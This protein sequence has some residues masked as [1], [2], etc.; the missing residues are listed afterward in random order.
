MCN[1]HHDGN[2]TLAKV[3]YPKARIYYER[4][5]P[6]ASVWGTLDTDIDGRI[7]NPV[8]NPADL[9]GFHESRS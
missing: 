4:I 2:M 1:G 8:T 3:L 5:E 9:E 7:D 6:V